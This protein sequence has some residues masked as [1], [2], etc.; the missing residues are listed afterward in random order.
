MPERSRNKPEWQIKIAKERIGILFDEAAKTSNPTL[1]KR[2]MQLAKRIG[3]RYNVR[4][5]GRKK[6][7][8]KYCYY[9][10]G[11]NVKRRLKDGKMVIKC[12]GCGRVTRQIYK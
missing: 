10:F 7:F 3:M 8:C 4:L 6:L 1:Q 2:Y 11:G 9:Y 5:E 12:P